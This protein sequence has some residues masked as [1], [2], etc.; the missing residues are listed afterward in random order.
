M[1]ALIHPAD[2]NDAL[3]ISAQDIL[4]DLVSQF[5]ITAHL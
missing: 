1:T 2:D 3:G 5:G 4:T